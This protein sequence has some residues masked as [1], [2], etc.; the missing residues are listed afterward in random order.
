ML[1]SLGEVAHILPKKQC[2]FSEYPVT[3][4]RNK[5]STMSCGSSSNNSGLLPHFAENLV[6]KVLE[7]VL[8]KSK[9]DTPPSFTDSSALQQS[10]S[11]RNLHPLNA[12]QAAQYTPTTPL[13]PTNLNILHSTA[14]TTAKSGSTRE[15]TKTETRRPLQ[16]QKQQKNCS[17][18]IAVKSNNQFHLSSSLISDNLP[19]KMEE[20]IYFGPGPAK[21]PTEVRNNIVFF[22]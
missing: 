20:F 8:C 1:I 13:Q 21:L 7:S 10:S 15:A 18:E 14:N 4:F 5:I 6:D 3:W 17:G 16:Q 19:V 9:R 22:K 11:S 12:Q 2:K